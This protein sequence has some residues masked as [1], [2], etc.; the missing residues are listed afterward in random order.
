MKKLIFLVLLLCSVVIGQTQREQETIIHIGITTVTTLIAYS[1][2][3]NIYYYEYEGK[4][5]KIGKLLT[6]MAISI[7]PNVAYDIYDI[8]GVQGNCINGYI[9][10]VGLG[11]SLVLLWKF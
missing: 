7:V 4:K 10:G 9:T 1:I 8:K 11:G 2:I 5:S 6:S 3:D